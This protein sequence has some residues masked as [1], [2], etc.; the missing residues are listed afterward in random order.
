MS[1]DQRCSRTAVSKAAIMNS[2]RMTEK[3]AKHKMQYFVISHSNIWD[4]STKRN[5][6]ENAYKILSWKTILQIY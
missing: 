5:T 1:L 4:L 3:Q 6:A 2:S